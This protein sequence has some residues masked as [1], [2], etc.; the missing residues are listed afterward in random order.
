MYNYQI[1][2]KLLE[3]NRV[4]RADFMRKTGVSNGGLANI[5][6]EKGNPSADKLEL[7]ADF[8][9]IPIDT[10][11]NRKVKIDYLTYYKGKIKGKEHH[12]ATEHTPAYGDGMT[13]KYIS[14]LEAENTRLIDENKDLRDMLRAFQNGDIT[15]VSSPKKP[16]D[17]GKCG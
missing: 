5:M 3:D 14:Q 13:Q 12:E 1:I 8:F 15:V 11:F 7:I 16:T 17:N 6:S 9:S 2:S 10:L 4:K